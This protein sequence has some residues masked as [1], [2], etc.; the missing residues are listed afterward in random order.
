MS[1]LKAMQEDDED[2]S[3]ITHLS[4]FKKIKHLQTTSFYSR[5]SGLTPLRYHLTAVFR[6]EVYELLTAMHYMTVLILIIHVSTY[7]KKHTEHATL[8]ALYME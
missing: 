8:A 6:P 4:D 5:T 7:F 2:L 1:N 3:S